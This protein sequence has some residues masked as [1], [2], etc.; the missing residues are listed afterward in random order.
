V[1]PGQSRTLTNSGKT[2]IFIANRLSDP[3]NGENNIGIFLE[4]DLPAGDWIVRLHGVAVTNGVFHAWIER[5]DAGQSSFA[6]PNDNSHTLGSISTGRKT[7]VVGSYDAHKSSTPISFF[8]SAGPT[9]DGRQKPE[10][11]APGHNVLAAWSRT[12]TKVTRK[13]GTSMA[14]PAVTGMVAL[15]LS[16]A[17][18]AGRSLTIDQIRDIVSTTARKSPP[19]AVPIWDSQYGTGRV[20]AS[21]AI[22][23]VRTT[24]PPPSPPTAAKKKKAGAGAHD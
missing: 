7:I 6:P 18:A 22:A 3:N 16:E 23:R 2:V 12:Q 8:S 14:T 5:D 9:R 19:A 13:S 21:G 24:A 1:E 10:V 4:S 11:S 20:S 17:K 15:I